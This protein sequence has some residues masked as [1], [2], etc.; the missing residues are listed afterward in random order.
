MPDIGKRLLRI[1]VFY[2]GGYFYHVNNYYR[3]SHE[4]KNRLSIA[5]IHEF[6]RHYAANEE[7][8][9]P[10]SSQIVDSHLF[11][12]RFSAQKTKAHAKL[13]AERTFDD[14]LMNEGVTTHYLPMLGK[15]EKGIDVWLSLEAFELAIH[16]QYD[17][18]VLIASDSD[19][20]PLVRKVNALGTRVMILG[21]DFEYTDHAGTERQT[22][23]SVRL[24]KEAA[25]PVM[26][27]EVIDNKT[28]RN[29]PIIQGLFVEGPPPTFHEDKYQPE[30]AGDE[31]QMPSTAAQA[32]AGGGDLAQ[33]QQYSRGLK[34]GAILT[35]KE[36]FGFIQCPEYPDNV[37]FHY[38]SLINRDFSELKVGDKVSFY[39]EQG[40]KG[41][42]AQ[43]VDIVTEAA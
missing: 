27:H 17:I 3:Y 15:V 23:T 21:W 8:I 40:E 29:D 31:L 39:V 36:G 33:Y 32:E 14:V 26:M 25:Y 42:V 38:S 12:G 37:F 18:L 16:K 28:K 35:L 13:F 20:V 22:V 34:T 2:D 7:G 6:I 10:R 9:D 41:H 19:F 43:D 30:D 1:G 5:G 24:L 4:R 11:R